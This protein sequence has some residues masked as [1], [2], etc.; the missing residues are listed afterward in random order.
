MPD[1]RTLLQRVELK[2]HHQPR[3]NVHYFME[4]RPMPKPAALEIVKPPSGAVCY[5]LYL[6]NWGAPMTETWHPSAQAAVYHAKWEYGI[7]PQEWS[8]DGP[9]AGSA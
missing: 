7:E 1:N 4:G 6:D 3:G 2:A 5:M 8:K 9:L